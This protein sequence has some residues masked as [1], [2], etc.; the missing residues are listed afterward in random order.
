MPDQQWHP[1][2]NP[3]LI[4][5]A[6]I[7]PTFMEVL[8]TSIAAVALPNIAGNLS[9]SIDE[10]TWVLTSYL[11]ANAVVLPASGWLALRVGRRRLPLVPASLRVRREHGSELR[12]ERRRRH[13]VHQDAESGALERR[14]RHERGADRAE[15]R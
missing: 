15:E 3:W 4:A 11:V 7:V 5:L 9:A 8:D 10:A 12:A 14:L 1:K 6:V 13:R 2:A